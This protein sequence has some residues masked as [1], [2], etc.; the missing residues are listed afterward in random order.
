[1]IN[2][3]SLMIFSVRKHPISFSSKFSGISCEF[4]NEKVEEEEEEEEE[5][6]FAGIDGSFSIF[7]SNLYFN[8]FT[9]FLLFYNSFYLSLINNISLEIN[10]LKLSI[11]F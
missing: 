8:C 11:H 3:Q 2:N 9:S 1:M 7:S 6:L 5:E 10:K 4:Y